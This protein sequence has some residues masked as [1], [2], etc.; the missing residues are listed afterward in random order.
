MPESMAQISKI[1]L[2]SIALVAGKGEVVGADFHHP[3]RLLPC[4]RVFQCRLHHLEC[5]KTGTYS[6]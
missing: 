1:I 4:D 3:L 2:T 6:K 5:K